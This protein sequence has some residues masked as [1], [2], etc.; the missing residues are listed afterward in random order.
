VIVNPPQI[1]IAGHLAIGQHP[2]EM[3]R[4]G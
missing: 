3:F 2:V 1:N 4:T